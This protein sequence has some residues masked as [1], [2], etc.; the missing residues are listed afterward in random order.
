M[1][2]L[3][4]STE[5]CNAVEVAQASLG[6]LRDGSTHHPNHPSFHAVVHLATAH[7]WKLMTSRRR[8]RHVIGGV[9]EEQAQ[10]SSPAASFAEREE[11]VFHVDYS[12]PKTHPPK[13]N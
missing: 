13:N 9:D 6:I 4:G 1:I 7:W 11:T 2:S 3:F 12:G 5:S 10:A 8:L